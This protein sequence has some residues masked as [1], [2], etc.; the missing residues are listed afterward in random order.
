M[1]R[2]TFLGGFVLLSTVIALPFFLARKK[3]AERGKNEENIRYDI[4]EYI[5]A[6]GL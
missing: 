6:E 5:A 3:M 4:D 1:K 2:F